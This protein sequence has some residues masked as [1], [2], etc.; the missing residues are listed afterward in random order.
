LRAVREHT[1]LSIGG[2]ECEDQA[3]AKWMPLL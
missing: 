3:E 1:A 2:V